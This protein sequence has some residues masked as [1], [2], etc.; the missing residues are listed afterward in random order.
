MRVCAHRG[1]AG[2]GPENTLAACRRAL[3]LGV[4]WVEVD[5]RLTADGVPVLLHDPTVDRTTDG[6]GPVRG[7][8]FAQLR[9]L[10]A[11]SWFGAGY[12]GERV[13]SLEELLQLLADYPGCGA[14]LELKEEGA[15][16]ER[17]AQVVLDQVQAAGLLGSVRVACFLPEPLRRARELV[18]QVPRVALQEVFDAADPLQFVRERQ[19]DVWG[20]HHAAVTRDRVQAVHGQG[21]AVYTWTVNDPDEVLRLRRAGLGDHPEDAVAT[22]LPDRVQAALEGREQGRGG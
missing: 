20:P 2:L 1:G 5:L 16:G 9:R 6:R 4:R 10:D 12:R 22:D 17:L 7:Y 3:E 15:T 8:S 11:G 13:P 21:V 19:A 14:Y 18:P